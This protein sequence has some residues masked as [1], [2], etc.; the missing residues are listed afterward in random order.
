MTR[1]RSQSR[2]REVIGNRKTDR[3]FHARVINHATSYNEHSVPPPSPRCNSFFMESFDSFFFFFF[4]SLIQQFAASRFNLSFKIEGAIVRGVLFVRSCSSSFALKDRSFQVRHFHTRVPI[5]CKMHCRPYISRHE[6][7]SQHRVA[8]ERTGRGISRA[9]LQP[10]M[11]RVR[12][13]YPSGALRV[14]RRIYSSYSDKY[15]EE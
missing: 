10:V 2:R 11:S 4:L 13:A 6:R 14:S 12:F 1:R 5:V 9:Y 7:I 8:S 3:L 15:L